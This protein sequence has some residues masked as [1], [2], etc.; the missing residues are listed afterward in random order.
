MPDVQP[1]EIVEFLRAQYD[2]EEELAKHARDDGEGRWHLADP[3][4]EESGRLEDERGYVVVYDEGRP[5]FAQATHIAL[6]DPA[7]ALAEL[8]AKRRILDLCVRW[9]EVGQPPPN[10]TWSDDA[11]GA[12][13]ARS[14]LRL[15]ALPDAEHPDYRPEWAPA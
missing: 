9:I 14:V 6:H 8:D 12:T 13:V 4:E 1:A 15:M 2:A 11:A 7:R 5:S 10:S 3:P